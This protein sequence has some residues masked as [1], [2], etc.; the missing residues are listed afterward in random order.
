MQYDP[1][2]PEKLLLLKRPP[3]ANATMNAS[4]AVVPLTTLARTTGRNNVAKGTLFAP[5]M[6]PPFLPDGWPDP[7]W[8]PHIWL[9]PRYHQTGRREY[10]ALIPKSK[11]GPDGQTAFGP[12][13]SKVPPSSEDM[14]SKRRAHADNLLADCAMCS[15]TSNDVRTDWGAT[16][17]MGC[18]GDLFA[19][20]TGMVQDAKCAT[21]VDRVRRRGTNQGDQGSALERMFKAFDS[22]FRGTP[23]QWDELKGELKQMRRSFPACDVTVDFASGEHEDNFDAWAS[24]TRYVRRFPQQGKPS[25]WFL[26]PHVGL[27]IQL[28]HRIAISCVHH[29]ENRL[30]MCS[31]VRISSP[32]LR[33]D[34][35]GTSHATAVPHG[36][37]EGDLPY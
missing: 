16:G 9:E 7:E 23:T 34:G 5:S 17:K 18:V 31:R 24:Y 35:R 21:P 37:P 14:A 28:T 15:I 25:L 10:F 33:W 13:Y 11:P 26:F 30:I 29:T 27:A 2:N 3:T 19:T 1:R 12:V 20:T 6:G 36:L 4:G 32:L 22:A 8:W